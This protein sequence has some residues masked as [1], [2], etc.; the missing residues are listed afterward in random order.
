[1]FE[2]ENSESGD[3]MAQKDS[4]CIIE[5]LA[6]VAKKLFDKQNKSDIRIIGIRYGEKMYKILLENEECAYAVDMGRF[7][8]ETA[9]KYNLNHDKYFSLTI[10]K[11]LHLLSSKL[12]T[13]NFL[14]QKK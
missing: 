11:G 13:L 9:D 2:F 12:I 10:V 8:R 4:A 1:M 14:L 5:A 6:K 7:Y 3:I